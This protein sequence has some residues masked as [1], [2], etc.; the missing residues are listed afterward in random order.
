L[1]RFLCFTIESKNEIMNYSSLITKVFTLSI[2]LSALMISSVLGQQTLQP[3]MEIKEDFTDKELN[4]FVKI[5]VEMIPIQ[6]KGQ[7][8]ML[9]TIEMEGLKVERFQELAQA[10]Q[11]GKLTEISEDPNEI[12]KFSKAGQ[13]VLEMQ[14]EV[15]VKVQ[16]KI[17][18]SKISEEKFQQIYMA[19]NQSDKVKAKIDK[20]M[21]NEID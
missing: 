3:Q 12:A 11:A 15:Q 1:E 19:Y 7:E 13:K 16:E 8:D 18:K 21:A 4:E 5:N 17:V 10:Q 6:E 2:V 20:L 14:Q 9:K